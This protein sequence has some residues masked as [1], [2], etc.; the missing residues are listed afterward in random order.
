VQL[1]RNSSDVTFDWFNCG[2]AF[3]ADTL[4]IKCSFSALLRLRN[5]YG[6][7]PFYVQFGEANLPIKQRDQTIHCIG[8]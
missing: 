4:A 6:G 7:F 5:H 1:D 3:A 8:K 2:A